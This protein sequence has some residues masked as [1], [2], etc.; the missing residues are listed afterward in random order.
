MERIKHLSKADHNEKFFQSLDIDK[1]NFRDWIV[2]GI[3]YSVVHYYEAYF[4]L[5]KKHSTSHEISD[6]WISNDNNISDTYY[7]YR[8]LKQERWEASYRAKI[9]S[10][11]Y[12]K[13]S[14]LP[15]FSNIK[16]KILSL[17]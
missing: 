1:T 17:N 9:F 3:F 16:M 2:V 15:K 14:I 5:Y 6:D 8:E 11:N 7:D 13:H 10:S 12:I 4:A